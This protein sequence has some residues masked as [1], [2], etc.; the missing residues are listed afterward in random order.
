MKRPVDVSRARFDALSA[1][2]PRWK[3]PVENVLVARLRA[4]SASGVR[5]KRPVENVPVA[6]FDAPSGKKTIGGRT[7]V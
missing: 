4:P 7:V 3:R 5:W 2:V 1:S 6:R